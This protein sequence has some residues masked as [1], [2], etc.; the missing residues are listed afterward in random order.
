MSLLM[1]TL[2]LGPIRDPDLISETLI[3]K[4]NHFVIEDNNRYL[5]Y[6]ISVLLDSMSNTSII[7]FDK[8]P[9]ILHDGLVIVAKTVYRITIHDILRGVIRK[10][11]KIKFEEN[12]NGNSSK[13]GGIE[14]SINT[15]SIIITSTGEDIQHTNQSTVSDE[16]EDEI[17]KQADLCWKE[18]VDSLFNPFHK[19][20]GRGWEISDTTQSGSDNEVSSIQD[21]PGNPGGDTGS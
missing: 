19:E 13:R 8:Y 14:K 18:Q 9:P 15:D 5:Y 20:A 3:I 4:N 6:K 21:S 2:K 1:S 12:T 11:R 16:D 7:R 10:Y 17:I